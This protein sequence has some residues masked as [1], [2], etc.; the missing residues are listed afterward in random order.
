MVL[1]TN[2]FFLLLLEGKEDIDLLKSTDGKH[3]LEEKMVLN[4]RTTGLSIP[5]PVSTPLKAKRRLK[6]EVTS[7]LSSLC[8]LAP[9]VLALPS[10]PIAVN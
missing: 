7:P 10:N 6:R 8:L 3:Y 5:L 2:T 1:Q 9:A 4:N